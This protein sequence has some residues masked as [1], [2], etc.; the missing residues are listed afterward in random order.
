MRTKIPFDLLNYLKLSVHV[1]CPA[2]K[3]QIDRTNNRTNCM[4]NKTSV[5]HWEWSVREDFCYRP[6]RC[7]CPT[8]VLAS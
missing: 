5:C 8:G 3:G 1:F 4:Q 2:E 6:F 7:D